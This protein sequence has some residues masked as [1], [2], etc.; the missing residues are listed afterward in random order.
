M[1]VARDGN[2]RVVRRGQP[3]A[4]KNTMTKIAHRMSTRISTASTGVRLR[5]ASLICCTALSI[6]LL[7]LTAS[8]SYL[9][10]PRKRDVYH[11]CRAPLRLFSALSVAAP[12]RVADRERENTGLSTPRVLLMIRDQSGRGKTMKLWL[13][14][15]QSIKKALTLVVLTLNQAA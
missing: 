1:M 8:P 13:N 14:P 7:Q 6:L 11:L 9:P 4:L 3:H 15:D 12:Y 5:N 2:H 10:L